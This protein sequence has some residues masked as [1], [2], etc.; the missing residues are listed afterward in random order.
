LDDK[1]HKYIDYAVDGAV[2]MQRLIN[3]LLDFSRVGTRGMPMKT[4][5]CNAVLEESLRNLAAMID[6][7]Q[8]IITHEVLPSVHADTSQLMLV[9]QNLI[10]NA[11]K[12]RGEGLPNVHVSAREQGPEWIFSV[13]DNGIGIDPKYADKIFLIFQRLHTRQEYPGTGMGLAIC[14]RIIERHGG[15]IWFES[16][17]GT[18]STFFFT[19]PK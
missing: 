4:I 12:F 3:D 2:R 15:R 18:G 5:D 10:S 11:I 6:E 1:A 9:F 16:A 17:P 14:K 13:K 19:I 8:A 7:S